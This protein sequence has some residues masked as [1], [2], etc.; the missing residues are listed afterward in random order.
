[1][2]PMPDEFEVTI[3]GMTDQGCD[4]CDSVNGTYILTNISGNP[5]SSLCEWQKLFDPVLCD[6]QG[7]DEI[8]RIV[9]TIRRSAN[10]K[11]EVRVDSAAFTDALFS[12]TFTGSEEIDC[13][14]FD[15]TDFPL[16][17]SGGACNEGS[18]TCKVTSL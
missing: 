18:A 7:F 8:D 5:L 12:I 1:M 15:E 13:M 11:I 3:A 2:G 6:G 17:E 16:T 14:Q 4:E 9:L 10:T